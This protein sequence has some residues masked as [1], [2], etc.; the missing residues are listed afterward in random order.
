ME[1]PPVQCIQERRAQR[2]DGWHPGGPETAASS[3]REP[4]SYP[5]ARFCLGY[6]LASVR[7]VDAVLDLLEKIETL[8]GVF[9]GCIRR[10]ILDGF[11]HLLLRRHRSAPP[12]LRT[13]KSNHGCRW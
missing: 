1:P 3:L 10:Q 5:L 7:L 12:G 2:T 4:P 11:E 13:P 8:H 6:L 9:D